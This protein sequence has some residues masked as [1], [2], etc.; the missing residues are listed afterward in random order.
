MLEEFEVFRRQASLDSLTRQTPQL[1]VGSM[2]WVA[3]LEGCESILGCSGLE[4][5]RE[6]AHIWRDELQST[7]CTYFRSTEVLPRYR[8]L[9]V[10]RA[11]FT[12]RLS[13]ALGACEPPYL[14]AI[15]GSGRPGTVHTESASGFRW[16]LSQSF[17]CIGYSPDSDGGPVLARGSSSDCIG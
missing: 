16:H 15:L 7:H 9:G 14:V 17:E 10:G 2:I 6:V 1:G 13:F 12:R 8:G 4:V 5:D 3:R 11:L